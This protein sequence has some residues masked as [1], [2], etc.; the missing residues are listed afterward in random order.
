MLKTSELE[1]LKLAMSA[2]GESREYFVSE[3]AGIREALNQGRL[4]DFD[5]RSSDAISCLS[6]R[7]REIFSYIAMGLPNVQ[8]AKKLYISPRT[9]ETHRAQIVRKLHLKSN[10]ELIRFAIKN[11]LTTV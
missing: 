10:G 2:L 11:G 6:P 1:D 9:V 7:E 8:I 5:D 3:V 4:V